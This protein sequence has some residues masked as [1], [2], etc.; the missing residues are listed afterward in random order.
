MSSSL[1][2]SNVIVLP[3][4]VNRV[5]EFLDRHEIRYITI[6]H[7]SSYTKDEISTC[8][9]ALGREMVE[10]SIICID[11]NRFAMIVSPAARKVSLDSLRKELNSPNLSFASKSEIQR[12]FPEC[13]VTAI[14]PFGNMFGMDMFFTHEMLTQH[15]VMFC[16]QS[17]ARRIHMSFKDYLTVAQPHKIIEVDTNARYLAQIVSV[18]PESAR[19]NLQKSDS[20]ILGFS[21]QSKNFTASKLAG[22]AEWVGKNFSHCIVLVGDSLNRITLEIKGL[23]PKRALNRALTIGQRILHE[24]TQIFERYAESC[25]FEVKLASEIFPLPECQVYYQQLRRL[26]VADDAFRASAQ[27]FADIFVGKRLQ[28]DPEH[29]RYYVDMSCTYLLEELAIFA[30]LADRGASA[31]V[32]PGALTLLQEITEGRHLSAPDALKNLTSISLDLKRR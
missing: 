5:C 26:L 14:P 11:G 20:C 29:F 30:Y 7:A 6:S 24:D 18:N 12:L 15:D 28:Q 22:L 21:L 17:H 8:E 32:Y 27:A 23:T 25:R 2:L 9:F 4:Y 13:D 3:Q 31:F 10:T 19:A 1:A 16:V